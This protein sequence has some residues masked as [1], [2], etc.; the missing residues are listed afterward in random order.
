MSELYKRI[1]GL[2]KKKGVTITEM[3]RQALVPRANLTELKMGRVQNIGLSSLQKIAN[4]FGVDIGYFVGS[5]TNPETKTAPGEEMS[6]DELLVF[7]LYGMEYKSIPKEK[8][9]E[10]RRYAEFIK[11]K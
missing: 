8:L 4:Y 7:A 1:D 5:E 10:I 6:G 9:A 3:C 2:C 11:D